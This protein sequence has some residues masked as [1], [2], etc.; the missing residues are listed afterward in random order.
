M[1]KRCSFCAAYYIKKRLGPQL[2]P[3]FTTDTSLSGAGAASIVFCDVKGPVASGDGKKAYILVTVCMITNFHSFHF[4][5]DSRAE[6]LAKTLFEHYIVTYASIRNFASDWGTN[7]V[8]K[9]TRELF[10]L[11]GTKVRMI[12][13][14][15]PRSNFSEKSVYL[16]RLQTYTVY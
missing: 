15:H 5:A 10:H 13:S 2:Y 7:Y 1:V 6:T 4:L 8:G 14:R 3:N 16:F 11:C 12:S 9:V